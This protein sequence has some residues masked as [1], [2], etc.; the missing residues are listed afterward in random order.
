MSR[1]EREAAMTKQQK[2]TDI[3][4]K[5]MCKRYTTIE[6]Q[7]LYMLVQFAFIHQE[8]TTGKAAD[9]LG[10]PLEAFR[11]IS[12]SWLNEPEKHDVIL[13][14]MESNDQW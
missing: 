11:A 10:L 4:L 3:I 6:Q 12:Q 7:D 1:K 5:A 14:A 8:I 13:P 9:L 2:M